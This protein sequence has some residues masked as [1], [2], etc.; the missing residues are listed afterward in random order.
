MA[1]VVRTEVSTPR[2]RGIL[3]C[4]FVR[5]GGLCAIRD[6]GLRSVWSAAPLRRV[7][8]TVGRGGVGEGE[9]LSSTQRVGIVAFIPSD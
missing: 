6:D 8:S 3:D 5:L 7:R 4:L 9:A 2:F 1:P